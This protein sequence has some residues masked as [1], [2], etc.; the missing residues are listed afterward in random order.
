MSSQ[1]IVNKNSVL[2]TLAITTFGLIGFSHWRNNH[3]SP[4]ATRFPELS[5]SQLNSSPQE[6]SGDRCRISGELLFNGRIPKPTFETLPGHNSFDYDYAYKI[7]DK[8]GNKFDII[9]PRR[10][11]LT[12]NKSTYFVQIHSE[13]NI[14]FKDLSAPFRSQYYGELIKVLNPVTNKW[15]VASQIESTD[16]P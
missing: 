5:I 10:L 9:S 3:F 2:G 12:H 8:D 4:E 16:Q 1:K 15:D 6:F 11:N 14:D 13:T 7:S